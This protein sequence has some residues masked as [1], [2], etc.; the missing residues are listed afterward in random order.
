MILILF[1]RVSILSRS[2]SI[3]YIFFFCVISLSLECNIIFFRCVSVSSK[4]LM[5]SCYTYTLARLDGV[6]NIQTC[7]VR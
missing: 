5:L 7:P 4:L 3:L 6:Y 1:R 2:L